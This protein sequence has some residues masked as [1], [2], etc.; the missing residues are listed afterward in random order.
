MAQYGD[1]VTLAGHNIEDR[2]IRE[3]HH[4]LAVQAK[5]IVG[6]GNYYFFVKE[7]MLWDDEEERN[8]LVTY[9]GWK[10]TK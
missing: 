1:Y 9:V 10:G 5:S 2:V 8:I 3:T 7:A 6:L 4:L